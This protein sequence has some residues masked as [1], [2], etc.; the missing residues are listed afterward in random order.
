[1]LRTLN[2]FPLSIAPDPPF[3]RDPGL[4]PTAVHNEGGTLP[5]VLFRCVQLESQNHW[6]L[7]SCEI[8]RNSKYDYTRDI[9]GG[10]AP[11]SPYNR[12]EEEDPYRP[13]TPRARQPPPPPS[14]GYEN[15]LDYPEG[16]LEMR[17]DFSAPPHHA[18]F[19][20]DDSIFNR[21]GVDLRITSDTGLLFPP[22]ALEL[23]RISKEFK[24]EAM[25]TAEAL[26]IRS[27]TNLPRSRRPLVQS[28]AYIPPSAPV[29]I[30]QS[31]PQHLVPPLPVLRTPPPSRI[32]PSRKRKR[33]STLEDEGDNDA[34]D[35]ASPS[36][37]RRRLIVQQQSFGSRVFPETGCVPAAP[38]AGPT[39][40]NP[41]EPSS[42]PVRKQGPPP[43]IGPLQMQREDSEIEGSRVVETFSQ[44][45]GRGELEIEG[46]PTLT[47]LAD[48]GEPD[49]TENPQ[50]KVKTPT[51][52]RTPGPPASVPE[53]VFGPIVFSARASKISDRL[54]AE[55]F[56][57]VDRGV[58]ISDPEHEIAN[59]S[60]KSTRFNLDS[61]TKKKE[62]KVF[63]KTPIRPRTL[64]WAIEAEN[65]LAAGVEKSWDGMKPLP[66]PK[67]TRAAGART[68]KQKATPSFKPE[69]AINSEDG[70][71]S[72]SANKPP[73]KLRRSKPATVQP[74]VPLSKAPVRKSTRS[75]KKN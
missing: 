55:V 52:S 7:C 20:S 25:Y 53:D 14:R 1:M 24:R 4:S 41:P 11:Q 38:G 63:R 75:K 50:S 49:S 69:T 59:I 29:P 51:K 74:Q 42:Q 56:Q 37:K 48:I 27:P 18:A 73:S 6:T 12:T 32:I 16:T 26:A 33:P 44:V 21:S 5:T 72:I 58:A 57:D 31:E 45:V 71:L 17:S 43:P 30:L 68:H 66:S 39:R 9:L 35:V 10:S 8:F 28:R 47:V 70:F 19:A 34:G 13:E 40:E 46:D 62:Y 36:I 22:S 54:P 67:K 65:A 60:H 61:G 64:S 2:F 23:A 3:N 15:D